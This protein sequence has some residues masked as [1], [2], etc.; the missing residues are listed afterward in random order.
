VVWGWGFLLFLYRYLWTEH[1]NHDPIGIS[2]NRVSK[3]R[4]FLEATPLVPSWVHGLLCLWVH[5]VQFSCLP[6]HCC[7]LIQLD[8]DVRLSA[9]SRGARVDVRNIKL[10][11]FLRF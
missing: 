7:V 8:L 6:I 2:L 9:Q 5:C 11:A 10:T 4:P 3:L 1:P